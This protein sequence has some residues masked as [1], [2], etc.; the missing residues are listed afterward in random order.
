MPGFPLFDQQ[1][2]AF[3]RRA[4]LPP[5]V[6]SDVASLLA[7]IA[8][9]DREGAWLEIGAGTGEIGVHLVRRPIRYVGLDRSLGMLRHFS[10][11]GERR[12]SLVGADA[13][14]S[15]PFPRASIGVVF[16]SR[17]LHFL[18]PRHL[19]EELERVSAPRGIVLLQGRVRRGRGS[20]R[21]LMRRRMRD[22][23]AERGL[24]GRGG[25][26]SRVLDQ[27]LTGRG[28]HRLP[29]R[30]AAAWEVAVSPIDALSDWEGKPGL[31]GLELPDEM[32]RA[33]L[34]GLEHWALE[35]FGD[36][37]ARR[38]SREVYVVEGWGRP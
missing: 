27:E 22:L 37:S 31:S 10:G 8:G 16:G 6:A 23:M 3:D 14:R 4:G 1:A 18:R 7:E 26:G 19:A 38:T 20:V 30:E 35:T 12:I 36:L 15:W 33:I 25:Q 24:A 34:Q 32:K 2:D 13:D 29:E 17:S 28:W 5:G 21:E 11:R 9:E